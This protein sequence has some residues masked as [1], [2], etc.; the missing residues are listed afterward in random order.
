LP[1]SKSAILAA[2]W[3]DKMHLESRALA[4]SPHV[5]QRAFAHA[6]VPVEMI[7]AFLARF[8]VGLLHMWHRGECGHIVFTHQASRYANGAYLFRDR[9]LMGTCLIGL[10]DLVRD[11]YVAMRPLLV[12]TDHLLG[13]GTGCG[14]MFSEGAGVST[15]IAGAAQRF[16]KIASLGYGME[17]WGE[18]GSGEY[19]C[20]SLWQYLTSP[21][22]LGTVDPLVHRLYT[23]TLMCAAWWQRHG[24]HTEQDR[25]PRA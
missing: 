17:H 13:S 22:E 18:S 7:Q 25:H 14:S 1:E 3:R 10:G 15:D 19:Y 2:I 9:S 8:P 23:Q 21:A 12:F 5:V 20:Q 16:C 24:Q 11:R 6:M 4:Q